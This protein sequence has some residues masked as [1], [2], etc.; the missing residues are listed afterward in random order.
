MIYVDPINMKIY[1]VHLGWQDVWPRFLNEIVEKARGTIFDLIKDSHAES[2][3]RALNKVADE[4]QKEIVHSGLSKVPSDTR[5]P[6]FFSSIAD[7]ALSTCNIAVPLAVELLEQ[8]VNFPEDYKE[9]GLLHSL[10]SDEEGV[11]TITRILSLLHDAGKPLEPHIL[12]TENI[13]K[14]FME[15]LGFDS[16]FSRIIAESAK[17]HH[18]G[19]GYE[20]VMPCTNLEWIIA[21][22]DKVSV[23]DR[24][25]IP[26]NI[27]LLKEPLEWLIKEIRDGEQ[28]KRIRNLLDVIQKDKELKESNMPEEL[29]EFFPI[30]YNRYIQLDERLLNASKEFNLSSLKLSVLFLEGEGI[31]RYINRSEARKY[32]S[33]SSSLIDALTNFIANDDELRHYVIYSSSGSILALV[34]SSRFTR[35]LKKVMSTVNQIMSGG[36]TFKFPSKKESVS[37]DLF[38]IK[39]GPYVSWTEGNDMQA[40]SKRNLGTLYEFSL[41]ELSSKHDELF[42]TK[43]LEFGKV[44]KVCFEEPATDK[45]RVGEEEIEIGQLCKVP[46]SY[47]NKINE[48]FMRSLLTVYIKG[49][50]VH[51]KFIEEIEDEL[52]KYS[53]INRVLTRIGYYIKKRLKEDET[54]RKKLDGKTFLFVK[55]ASL[56]E[57][58]RQSLQALKKEPKEDVYDVAYIHG[59]GDNFGVMKASM[60]NITLYR[61][62]SHRFEE[63]IQGGVSMGLA[64]VLL[65]QLSVFVE[66]NKDKL[67]SDKILLELPFDV[68]YIGGDDFRVVIDPA[69]IWVFLKKLRDNIKENFGSRKSEYKK[70][71]CEPLSIM[72]LGMSIA[73]VVVPNRMPIFAVSKALNELEKIAKRRSKIEQRGKYG[74]EICVSFQRFTGLP[75]DYAVNS[76][77]K[78]VFGDK[79]FL[80]AWP[81][82]G[83]EIFNEKGLMKI[84]GEL[85]QKGLRCNHVRNAVSFK[86][87]EAGEKL[88]ID[89][90]EEAKLRILYKAT[91]VEESREGYRYLAENLVISRGNEIRFQNLDI[92]DVMETVHEDQI[93]LPGE[94]D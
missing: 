25:F 55:T 87:E 66:H 53:P 22:A 56:D 26:K 89:T 42:Q 20:N 47:L 94:G 75:G 45:V 23:Q 48:V 81:R 15:E 77:Y 31:Q 12:Y 37:Y 67:N 34:P 62:I 54:L 60:S 51:V 19:Q 61:T 5:F 36:F 57:L 91:R 44:C 74:G 35:I 80:T 29:S 50:D 73:V 86:Q 78:P 82:L 24:I 88:R 40:I 30:N 18:Y 71:A 3:R 68:L 76:F 10:L 32:L 17:R 2:Y 28:V 72:P 39:N 79:V 83:Q 27:K 70:A 59:D 90:A 21:F 41:Y 58:G 69:W 1:E 63:I 52:V 16:E 65:N 9:N 13:I 38:E 6:G 92:V 49:K 46:Y 7:H 4:L 14:Q 11:I 93:F 64:E 84:T 33:G 85:L 43:V 8:G